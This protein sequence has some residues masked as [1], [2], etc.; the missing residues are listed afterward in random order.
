MRLLRTGPYEP[1]RERF[2]LIERFGP[3]IENYAI[4]SHRCGN[5][6]VNYEDVRDPS[7]FERRQYGQNSGMIFED[8]RDESVRERE[9]YSKVVSAMRQ[10]ASDGHEYIWIDT[11]CID[12]SNSA[13]LSEGINSM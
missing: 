3:Q 8:I 4:L 11:C 2:E 7:A 9:G 1:G 5:D 12:K 13:E 6:D 10:A